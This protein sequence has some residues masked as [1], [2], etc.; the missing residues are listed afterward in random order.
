VK[1][2]RA[3]AEHGVPI[4]PVRA[5][6]VGDRWRKEPHIK[7]W[8]ARATTDKAQIEEWWRNWP[9]A[10][11]G[12]PLNRIDLVIVDCDRHGDGQDGV[13]LL[14]AID[15]PPHQAVTTLS[16]GEHHFFRQPDPPIRSVKWEGGEVLGHGRFVVA[17]SLAPFITRAPALPSD[18]L[19]RLPKT[20]VAKT[21]AQ[22]KPTHGPQMR[23]ATSEVPKPLYFEVLRLVPL[24]DKVTLHHRRRVIG[25]LKIVTQ[26]HEGRNGALNV[27]AFCFRELVPE[28]VSR[29]AAERLLFS[30]ARMNGYVAKDGERAAMATIRSGLGPG[31]LEDHVWV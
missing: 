2:A 26:R 25:I 1:L 12:V 6:R 13:A 3:L 10:M 20:Q 7:D 16:N 4:F 15:L 17:Y 23:A 8:A 18:L 24:S 29:D 14:Q 21:Q 11:V 31:S 27:A 9:N 22:I 19:E 5:Y 28:I 30:A